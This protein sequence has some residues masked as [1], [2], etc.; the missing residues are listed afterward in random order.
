MSINQNSDRNR[1]A[2]LNAI[3]F[4]KASAVISVSFGKSMD[5][6]NDNSLLIP[7]MV[8][9]AFSCELYLKCLYGLETGSPIIYEHSLLKLFNNL[10]QASR[11]S[12]EAHFNKNVQKSAH[13]Q[14]MMSDVPEISFHI[15]DVLSDVKEVF[16]KFR[17]YHEDV[18]SLR[19]GYRGMKEL[20]LAVRERVFELEPSYRNSYSTKIY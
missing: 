12:I 1:L 9:G 16:K 14:A 11:D 18:A 17:Y 3:N 5:N 13:A 19:T 10:T 7:S 4:D 2:F 15:I 20:R 8:N 6:D